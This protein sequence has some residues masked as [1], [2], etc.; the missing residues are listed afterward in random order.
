M[1][2]DSSF[3]SVLPPSV[4]MTS[5]DGLV[6]CGANWVRT[7]DDF[8]IFPVARLRQLGDGLL[9]LELDGF[10]V[11]LCE[12]LVVDCWVNETVAAVFARGS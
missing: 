3:E 11:L 5:V 7:D 2:L 4:R 6:S 10:V 12:Y 8:A 1:T 9:E